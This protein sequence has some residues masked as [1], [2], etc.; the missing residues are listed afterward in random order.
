MCRI[1]PF[2]FRLTS[3][4]LLP[5]LLSACAAGLP[6]THPAA[7]TAFVN[8][9]APSCPLR[10][11]PLEHGSAADVLTA[12][13]ERVRTATPVALDPTVKAEGAAFG[14]ELTEHKIGSPILHLSA[15][16]LVNHDSACISTLGQTLA[17]L[18]SAKPGSVESILAARIPWLATE[19]LPALPEPIAQASCG[20]HDDSAASKATSA[21]L[22]LISF[23]NE[24]KATLLS[25]QAGGATTPFSTT[26]K[27]ELLPSLQQLAGLEPFRLATLLAARQIL[28]TLPQGNAAA[29]ESPQLIAL[30][31]IFNASDFLATYFDAYFRDNQ[32]I[33]LKV[34][35][36][37]LETDVVNTVKSRLNTPLPDDAAKQLSATVAAVCKKLPGG[38]ASSPAPGTASFV[39]LFGQSVQFSG[40]TI[41]WGDT[42][43]AQ[44][45]RPAFTAPPVG[46]FGPQMVQVLIEALFDA[47][48]PH[49]QALSTSTACA[50]GLYAASE[51]TP[52]PQLDGT[53]ARIDMVGNTTQALVTTGVGAAIRGG[54]WAALNNETVAALIETFA[55]VTTRKAVQQVMAFCGGAPS[56]SVQANGE[57]P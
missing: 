17:Q 19:V 55:G 39:T 20:Q 57:Q 45:W 29:M 32:F 54:G 46:T 7:S 18:K 27:Q 22:N 1:L 6:G 28:E 5:L 41:A 13:F 53:L 40:V 34:N 38:C 33:Q 10:T 3:S 37:S 8:T 49:P 35:E 43:S 51:C 48:G 21:T 25:N 44:P 15:T 14:I 31:A 30:V 9:V 26:D 42:S 2:P 50:S 11:S 16:R 4:A 23:V 36:Q 12:T 52:A 56:A 24:K 47:N